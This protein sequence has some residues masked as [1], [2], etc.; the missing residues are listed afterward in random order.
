MSQFDPQ[1]FL[2][3][4]VTE[5]ND[6]KIIPIPVGEW[7]A[8]VDDV[9]VRPWQAKNDSSKA[10]LALD[11][12]WNIQ[13]PGVLGIVQREKATVKQGLMLDLT[14]QG[15]LDMG[16]GKNVSLGRLREAVGLNTPGKPFAFSMLMGQMA[17]VKVE[18]RVVGE[19]IFSDVKAV[20]KL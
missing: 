4:Q 11:V 13:D 6:T 2:D 1:Q 3:M 9:K 5:Q 20:T 7:P 8:Q 14:E 19:D 17:K 18:H 10:G 15:G 12:T 16:K